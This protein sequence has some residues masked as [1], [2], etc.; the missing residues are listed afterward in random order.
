MR[1]KI[2]CKTQWRQFFS[3][4][5]YKLQPWNQFISQATFPEIGSK[6]V[7]L[8]PALSSLKL[9]LKHRIN[10][11]NVT[12][13]G[14]ILTLSLLLHSLHFSLSVML[15]QWRQ[16]RTARSFAWKSHLM[17]DSNILTRHSSSVGEN[18]GVSSKP[19][20]QELPIYLYIL[21]SSVEPQ[22]AWGEYT[23]LMTFPQC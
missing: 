21:A 18:F 23:L 19:K 6:D 20:A 7:M 1:W 5:H 2:P 8:F 22:V 10:L 13:V 16:R 15:L 12:K 4:C 11:Q 17:L 9:L 14:T 3:E